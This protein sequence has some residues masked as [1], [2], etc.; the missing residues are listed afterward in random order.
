MLDRAKLIK[1]IYYSLFLVSV[2]LVVYSFTYSG[3]FTTDD[4]HILASRTLS[5][6]FDDSINDYRVLG[7]SRI[8]TYFNL[9][10]DYGQQSLNIEPMQA[11]LGAQ[12]AKFA[13]TLHW[14]KIQTIF[15]LNILL[16]AFT[17]G[18]IFWILVLLGF[19]LPTSIT[20]G[21]LFGLCTMIWPYSKTY[22]RDPSAMFFVTLAWGSALLLT[23]NR[24]QNK[25][26]RI[27]NSLLWI[28]FVVN[29]LLGVLSKNSTLLTIPVFIILFIEHWRDI[30]VQN[31]KKFKNKYKIIIPISVF[32]LIS[33]FTIWLFLPRQI[34]QFSRFTAFY[35][36]TVIGNI[37]SNPHSNFFEGIIGPII[38]PGKSIF[39]FSPV[40]ILAIVGLIRYFKKS[41]F[42]WLY[43]IILVIVQAL[44][45][46]SI[47]WG[48]VNWG[49]RFLLPA[50]PILMISSAQIIEDI[51][52]KKIK[53]PLVPLVFISGLIQIIGTWLPARNYYGYIA[54]ST[55]KFSQSALIWNPQ[56][57]QIWWNLSEIIKGGIPDSA[58]W[59]IGFQI[60]PIASLVIICLG[61]CIY[62]FMKTCKPNLFLLAIITLLI[63]LGF[64]ILQLGNDPIYQ[65]RAD[66]IDSHNIIKE[67]HSAEDIIFIRTYGS[68]AWLYW[69]NWSDP[70]LKWIS[71]SPVFERNP[72]SD[73]SALFTGSFDTNDEPVQKLLDHYSSTSSGVWIVSPSNSN[74]EQLQ[75]GALENILKYRISKEWVFTNFEK[76]T[77]VFLLLPH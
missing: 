12:F 52:N 56:F 26:S 37:F 40:L 22:F 19:N 44:Y 35:Y 4:E 57:T 34:G 21:F 51:F 60:L 24:S 11:I 45:Y 20:T 31:P 67:N 64:Y 27:N 36:S 6:A 59:R 14:G 43:F 63:S 25:P 71:L 32:I 75:I 72:P 1:S 15:F 42:A 33:L 68:P 7:N 65:P 70:E 8:L 23:S 76:T 10:P 5:M 2:L 62:L 3:T 47:W 73:L 48:S 50:I 30:W 13:N 74:I 38:S 61:M 39:L 54:K 53:F 17:A 46:D 58:A 9:N 77:K 41:Y 49:L 55:Q 69:M 66:L 16:T 28:V 18:S 29:I